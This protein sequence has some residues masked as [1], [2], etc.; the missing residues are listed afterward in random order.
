MNIGIDVDGT[1][2]DIWAYMI[3]NGEKYFGRPASDPNA[4]EIEQMF[5]CSVEEGHAFWK[6]YL[7]RYCL[8]C[9]IKDG[10]ARTISKLRNDGHHIYI[11][12]SRVFTTRKGAAGALFRVIL[13]GWLRKS[14]VCYEGIAF[15][16]DSGEAK[17]KECQRLHI[18]VMIDDKPENLVTITKKHAVIACPMP[19]NRTLAAQGFVMAKDWTDIYDII[20][21]SNDRRAECLHG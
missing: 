19:W 12:T 4:F 20:T 2:T 1:L 10:A 17:L 16:E 14:G 7:L 6:K 9:P 11:V 3:R 18:D 13:K 15:C 21:R 8:R 5:A